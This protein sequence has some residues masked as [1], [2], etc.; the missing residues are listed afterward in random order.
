MRKPYV[1]VFDITTD[2]NPQLIDRDAVII[3][4]LSLFPRLRKPEVICSGQDAFKAPRRQAVGQVGQ[5]QNPGA[6]MVL[7]DNV[8]IDII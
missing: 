4:I 6:R 7:S 8:I 5:G 2:C 1:A 3:L